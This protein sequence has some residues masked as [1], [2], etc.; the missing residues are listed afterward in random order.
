[1]DD[2]AV[3]VRAVESVGPDTLAFT[4]ETPVDFEA[5]P[6]QFVEVS[7]RIDGDLVKR[8]FTL[9]S[10]D[11]EDTFE[12]T[13]SIDPEGALGP[14]LADREPGDAI[15][16]SGPHGRAF[17]DG[18]QSVV[19]LAAGPGIGPAIGIGERVIAEDG[20]VAIV[21]LLE[22]AVH[23]ARLDAL[24]ASGARVFPVSDGLE[25]P[26]GEAVDQV[27]GTVFVYGFGPFVDRAVAAL[28]A[29]GLDPDEAK[30]ESFGPGP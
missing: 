23:E 12:L 25:G 17:Y 1:M 18:E 11:V 22:T 20:A 5:A 6:G 27:G 24:A 2:V 9:S 10:P 16:I 7:A 29:A 19:V 8:Y 26:T 21:Y 13:V 15:R 14:W 4:F 3:T 28:E 30:V